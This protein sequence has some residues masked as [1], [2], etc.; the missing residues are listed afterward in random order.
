MR[1]RPIEEVSPEKQRELELAVKSAMERR[2]E[3][4]REAVRRELAYDEM[5]AE[6]KESASDASKKLNPFEDAQ[7]RRIR[8]DFQRPGMPRRVRPQPE[9]TSYNWH[10][11]PGVRHKGRHFFQMKAEGALAFETSTVNLPPKGNGNSVVGRLNEWSATAVLKLDRCPTDESTV[12]EL[13]APR[14]PEDAAD[15][16]APR[17]A[18]VLRTV[19]STEAYL[20]FQIGGRWPVAAKLMQRFNAPEFKNKR[21]ALKAATWNIVTVAVALPRSVRVHLNGECVLELLADALPVAARALDGSDL[22][23]LRAASASSLAFD[24][25]WSLDPAAGF[26][27]FGDFAS[28]AGAS[29]KGANDKCLRAVSLC[30]RAVA[31]CEVWT[32]HVAHGVAL[33]GAWLQAVRAGDGLKPSDNL[34]GLRNAPD[35]EDCVLQHGAR[36]VGGGAAAQPASRPPG[37]ADHHGGDL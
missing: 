12:Y 14:R 2:R 26:T 8:W 15:A 20:S 24:G 10:E 6:M 16:D 36:A 28:A 13:L 19:T 35:A 5:V 4:Q 9:Q 33:P 34:D 31:A 22:D 1:T 3:L 29:A 11:E 18:L 32:E 37:P 7:E 17:A 21:I 30:A 25:P 23:A 27:L